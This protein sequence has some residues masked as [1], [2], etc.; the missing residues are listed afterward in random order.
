MKLKSDL[1]NILERID[2]KG[3]PAYKETKGEYKFD[4][5][6]LNIEHV[7]GDPFASPSQISII[8]NNQNERFPSKY[9]DKNFKRIA[10]Q[11][12]L[13]RKIGFEMIKNSKQRG[14]GKSGLMHI[15]QCGQEILDRTACQI[16]DR[17]GK[18]IIRL[19]I[20][21]PANGRIINAG[22]LEKIFFCV[23]PEIVNKTL[24]LKI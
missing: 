9:Y 11:D 18:I 14:S 12:Y 6:I 8:V 22:E 21:F 2:H 23:L 15:S 16:H 10:V 5:Y 20:G 24:C 1:K 4:D 3:Y 13:L 7:Q 19:E 17:D